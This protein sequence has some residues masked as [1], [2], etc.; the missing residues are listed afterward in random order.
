MFLC[1]IANR[2]SPSAVLKLKQNSELQVHSAE[3]IT[4]MKE[5]WPQAQGLLIRSGTKVNK[6]L[7]G[8]MPKLKVVISATSGF[9]H[10]DLKECQSR[11]IT[12]MHTPLANIQS[13]AEHTWGLILASSR[14]YL[15]CTDQ[16]RKGNWQRST[17]LGQEISGKSL[18]IIGFGRIGQRVYK[19][20]EAFAMKIQVHDPY[21]DQA[22]FPHISFLG[23]EEVVRNSD[24]I[25]FHVPLTTETKNMVNHNSLEWFNDS[26]TLVNASRGAVIS[27][28]ALLSFLPENPQF[29]VALDV[30]PSEPLSKESSLLQNPNVYCT[31]HVGA[32]TEQAIAKASEEA[33]NKM[34]AF[35]Q[36]QKV[37][38]PLPPQAI[39]A[40][41]LIEAP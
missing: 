28:D 10:I 23:Y 31:P 39:W 14:K 27:M 22:P 9:D 19:I 32:T 41:K 16:I 4:E 6:K 5:F 38:D 3:D 13:A 30:F 29:S 15:R 24:I 12:V 35:V 21:V 25:T 11:Q 8:E 37:S 40:E 2:F 36:D 7:L 34:I 17:L 1:L 33:V 26:A 18:G 20:A